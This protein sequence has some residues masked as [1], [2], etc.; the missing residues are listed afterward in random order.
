MSKNGKRFL[1]LLLTA[2]LVFGGVGTLTAA[3]APVIN[4]ASPAQTVV[5][6]GASLSFSAST[7]TTVTRVAVINERDE[8]TCFATVPTSNSG[9]VKQ[10]SLT[11]PEFMDVGYRTL[12]LR[13]TGS[14]TTDYALATVLV[15]GHRAAAPSGYTAITTA[16]QLSNIRNNLSGKYILMN[17][18]DLASWGNWTPIGTFTGLLDGNGYAVKNMT[19]NLN[20]TSGNAF[21]GLIATLKGEVKN[22]GIVGGSIQATA[23]NQAAAGG[24]A[25]TLESPG[26]IHGCYN[27][28]SVY[29]S[30]KYDYAGGIAGIVWDGTSIS[31]CANTGNITAVS[32][33]EFAYAGGMTGYVTLETAASTIRD[34][35]NS[36]VIRAEASF[37]AYA[38]G[39]AGMMDGTASARL[40][41]TNCH[42]WGAVSSTTPSATSGIMCGNGYF[43]LSN[44]YYLETTATRAS[45]YNGSPIISNVSKL[46]DAQMRQQSSF[47]NFDFS[48]IWQ[49]PSGGYPVVRFIGAIHQ[50]P[51]VSSYTITYNANGGSVSPASA[52]VN[53]GSSVTTPTPTKSYTL[54]YNVNGGNSVSPSS[55]SVAST[56][57]GWYTAASGGTKRANAGAAYTP[58]QTETI[59]AQWTNPTMGTLPTPTHSTSGYTFKGWFTA[60]SGGTQVTSTTTMTA[61]QTIYAQW[62]APTT[63]YTITYNA[64]GGSVSPTNATA[65][66]GSSVTT[67]TPTKSYT[68]TYNANGG[69]AVS[70]SSK[71][72]A[73]T[74]N[75]WYTA[76]SG[77]TKRANAGAAYTPTQTETIYAQWANP[78]MGTLPTPTRSGYT[79]K[80][81]FTASSGG[82]QVTSSTA[83][84]ANQT[85]YAQWNT[86]A[87]YLLSQNEIYSFTNSS[88]HFTNS[89]IQNRYV[90][91]ADFTK[92]SN[93]AK[94]YYGDTSRAQTSINNMQNYMRLGWSGSCYGMAMTAVLDKIG[95]IGM[96]ENF[97]PGAA[98]LWNVDRPITNMSVLS[99]IN[100]YQI[101]QSSGFTRGAYI[102]KDNAN[103]SASLQKL[104]SDAKAGKLIQFSYFYGNNQ[105][106][107]IVIVGYKQNA[108]GS[109]DLIAW[110]N[111]YTD[112]RS[113]VNVSSDYKNCVVEG[114]YVC[115]GI[116]FLSDFSIL[117]RIDIDGPSN[118]M[119][120]NTSS[121]NASV[122]TSEI[123]L[124]S[125]NSA[126]ITNAAGQTLAFDAATGETSGTMDVLSSHMIVESTVDGTPAPVRF[127]FEVP[128]SNI[129]TLSAE[130]DGVDVAITSNVMFAAASSAQADTVVIA[131]NEGVYVMGDGAMDYTASLSLN[132][133][134]CDMVTIEGEAIGN[135]SLNYKGGDVVADG[136]SG[137]A[138]LTVFSNTVNVEEIDFSTAYNS[139]LVTKTN[140][141]IDVR[142]STQG[143]GTYDVSVLASTFTVTLNPN[144]GSVNPA[145]I[146]VT[147][148]GTYSALP[149]PN[150]DGHSFN[151]WYTAASGGTKIN[152]NSTVN[153]SGPQT[154][155][156]QWSAKGIFGTNAKW[157]GAWWH[158]LLFFLGFGWIWMW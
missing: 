109:H 136:V 149:M 73:C 117:D 123:T 34:C 28:A 107:A 18:I 138:I 81:W 2:M 116:E 50:P 6:S 7:D 36:G 74:V 93:Y 114:T 145:S 133:S 44:C 52:T 15:T 91:N 125:N 57:N 77:G 99:A 40:T 45:A 89:S 64:N 108:N 75:G 134:L 55:K 120:V 72:V 69:N 148:G 68:L 115:Y 135:S 94:K 30:S 129:Y 71:S 140:G 97:D 103:W 143:N 12:K 90:S 10:W 157:Y 38:G 152:P 20:V 62:N 137:G 96:N 13:A 23:S 66:A 130:R 21:G 17:D 58:T 110:N 106:H 155:Y 41:T 9:G 158:Y 39:I 4:S 100:Y 144:G 142:A 19:V 1:S 63:T 65:N 3:A 92:L 46:T 56:V 153:L 22:L 48:T 154:L 118:N 11:I 156:A 16:Q 139:V 8:E 78:T 59:Y 147:N 25:G 26:K 101:S 76:T 151:G 127:V 43:T 102:S 88:S 85:I 51:T 95:K 80:G 146:V 42:N 150:R 31:Q 126:T 119:V 131:K 35:V 47:A 29:T 87:A 84:T 121:T 86:S 53:A 122:N 61:N 67:P 60:S 32:T 128:D 49:M 111:W 112:F 83:M 104:V 24:I 98:S 132:N 79:F 82:T 27:R 141:N 54:T 33:S 124:L 5:Q 105:G 70:P 37:T 113:I 14:G